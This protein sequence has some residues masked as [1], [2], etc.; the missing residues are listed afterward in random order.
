MYANKNQYQNQKEEKI[1]LANR[2][3]EVEGIKFI[4][5]SIIN[6]EPLRKTSISDSTRIHF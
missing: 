3:H 5:K 1:K 2:E 4:H 6:R